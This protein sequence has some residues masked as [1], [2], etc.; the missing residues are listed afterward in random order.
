MKEHNIQIPYYNSIEWVINLSYTISR[1]WCI[2][3]FVLFS[4]CCSCFLLSF[5]FAALWCCFVWMQFK[6]IAYRCLFLLRLFNF[7]WAF[8]CVFFFLSFNSEYVK[9]TSTYYIY[10]AHNEE[11][12]TKTTSIFSTNAVHFFSF[13]RLLYIIEVS[14]LNYKIKFQKKLSF[15]HGN[16]LNIIFEC[17]RCNLMLNGIK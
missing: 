6:H 3:C 16:V 2:F 1:V 4:F 12:Q 5:I 7:K 11:T 15:M 13:S 8:L 14:Y 9:W 17:V 10:R